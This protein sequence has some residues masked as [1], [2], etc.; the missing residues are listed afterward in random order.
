MKKRTFDRSEAMTINVSVEEATTK[1][2]ELIAGLGPGD[3]IVI[4]EENL[5]I[6]RLLG[7]GK[8]KQRPGPGLCKGVITIVS[9]DDEHLAD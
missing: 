3:E 2:R 8:P 4:M 7:S 5:P 1:L 9:D 6:A